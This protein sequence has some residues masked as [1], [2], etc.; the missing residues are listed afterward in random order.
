M[1]ASAVDPLVGVRQLWLE[2]GQHLG[3]LILGLCLGALVTALALL[4]LSRIS[5]R[6]VTTY[7]PLFVSLLL[8]GLA[9]AVLGWLA[10]H[11]FPLIFADTRAGDIVEGSGMALAG[12]CFSVAV[13]EGVIRRTDR[14]LNAAH[15]LELEVQALLRSALFVVDN[16]REATVAS[17]ASEV[18]AFRRRD[19]L[20]LRS[21]SY[22]RDCQHL[23]HFYSAFARNA[24]EA[25]DARRTL[26]DTRHEMFHAAASRKPPEGADPLLWEA[27]RANMLLLFSE[28]FDYTD[29]VIKDVKYEEDP[30]VRA[31]EFERSASYATVDSALPEFLAPGAPFPHSEDSEDVEGLLNVFDPSQRDSLRPQVRSYL[32]AIEA[33]ERL[34]SGLIY[35]IDRC[36]VVNAG[37]LLRLSRE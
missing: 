28:V 5:A 2:S 29:A 26:R 15:E 35:L 21:Q 7:T 36:I 20:T 25:Q 24:E 3:P 37:L 16:I 34:K 4:W 8:I 6:T 31:T 19:R 11:L 10:P 27:E 13:L 23:L 22:A 33:H 17:F 1:K 12:S 18:S 32:Q 9:V 14:R 30:V